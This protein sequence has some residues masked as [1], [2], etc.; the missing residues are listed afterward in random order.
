MTNL[1]H[2]TEPPHILIVD[3]ER[4]T[5]LALTESFRQSGFVAE[6]AA[7]GQEALYW[8][9]Q[10]P[11]AVVILDLQ[12]PDDMT[13][14]DILRAA[15]TLAPE[16]AFIMLTG[17]ATTES[18][19]MALRS[20][21][22]DYL[23]KPATWPMILRATQMALQKRAERLREKDAVKLLRQ[24]WT[25]LGGGEHTA[26]SLPPLSPATPPP[27]FSNNHNSLY[28]VGNITLDDLSQEVTQDGVPL[29]LTPIEYKLL[30][31]LLQHPNILF[32]YAELVAITH[33]M[34]QLDE[35]EART[36]LRTHVFRLGRKLGDNSPL[37]TVRGRGIVLKH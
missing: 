30:A 21:A 27:P 5:R 15:E 8:L 34:P 13:G 25:T 20:G 23:Q 36:L 26:V 32:S 16:T 7:T 17:Y 37:Q 18:A 35:D 22:Y 1:T 19:I 14:L 28:Q 31:H 4:T 10:K 12:L 2:L 33:D 24:A 3:D 6:G 29:T 11:F 9:R